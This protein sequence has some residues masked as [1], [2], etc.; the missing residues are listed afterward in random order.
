MAIAVPR[1]GST[2]MSAHVD[3][4]DEAER[5]DELPE[6]L[7]R[8]PAGEVPSHPDGE[9]QLG[10]LGRLEGER[11]ERNPPMSTVHL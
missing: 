6:G 10:E 1:S 11:S 7:G 8:T 4:D 9:R 2:R 5:L 3:A